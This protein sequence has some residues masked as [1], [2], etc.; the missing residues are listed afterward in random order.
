MGRHGELSDLASLIARRVPPKT[1]DFQVAV[2]SSVNA[3]STVTLLMRGGLVPDVQTLEGV[4]LVAGDRVLVAVT[5]RST[6]YVLG[7]IRPLTATGS[8]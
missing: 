3:D 5:G 2:V 4:A 7:R 8:I 1:G 6:R